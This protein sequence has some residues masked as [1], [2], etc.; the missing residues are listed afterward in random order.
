M[1]D[2]PLSVDEIMDLVALV[3]DHRASGQDR[4]EANNRI[5]AELEKL[6]KA[7]GDPS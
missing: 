5:R 1:S 7:A 6:V 2:K 3:A 4:W